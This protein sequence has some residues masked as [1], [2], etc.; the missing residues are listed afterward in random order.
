[1]S[2]RSIARCG[3]LVDR[4]IDLRTTWRC[5]T[6][7]LWAKRSWPGRDQLKLNAKRYGWIRRQCSRKRWWAWWIYLPWFCQGLESV[8]HRFL[9]AKMKPFDRGDVVV[10]WVEACLSGR[11]WRVHMISSLLLLLFVNDLP[12][13]LEALTLLFADNVNMVT[14]R[15]QE[16]SLHSSLSVSWD[17]SM[18]LDLLINPARSNYLTIG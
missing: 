7:L 11:V 17:R 12:D 18:K 16:M 14:R 5:F 6:N 15:T 9:L 10:R 4:R 1:M 13:A 3:R 8:N 2:L